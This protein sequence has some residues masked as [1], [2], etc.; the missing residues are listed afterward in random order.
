MDTLDSL[1]WSIF[2]VACISAAL[3]YLKEIARNTRIQA[4]QPDP[5]PLQLPKSPPVRVWRIAGGILVGVLFL[6][7]GIVTY[8]AVSTWR[9][10]VESERLAQ[11]QAARRQA[12]E[13]EKQAEELR[14]FELAHQRAIAQREQEQRQAQEDAARIAAEVAIS[15]EQ[16]QKARE[17]HE[18][19]QQEKR[20]QAERERREMSTWASQ[21]LDRSGSLGARLEELRVG[22]R[23]E[24]SWAG[25][26]ALAE[27]LRHTLAGPEPPVSFWAKQYR[28]TLGA[29]G[30]A[31]S[32]CSDRRR[33]FG[34]QPA[35]EAAI[36]TEASFRRKM[37]ALAEP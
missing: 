11:E 6:L 10:R 26:E 9:E 21:F 27:S 30:E 37:F 5:V 2:L 12:E 33:P 24:Q 32:F 31:Q 7:A 35:L 17:Q 4:G 19:R 20:L 15:R 25:C 34:A 3:G 36:E 22:L 29:I 23:T 1:F 18:A 28:M 14:Q 13:R 8:G 16:E